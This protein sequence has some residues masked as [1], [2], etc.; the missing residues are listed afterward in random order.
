MAMS[1]D[2]FR[3]KVTSDA[4]FREQLKKDPAGVL[5][6]I[7]WDVPD[8]VDFEVVDM[9]GSKQYLVL[10]PLQSSELKEEELSG[11]QGGCSAAMFQVQG[12]VCTI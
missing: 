4:A 2:E 6:S 8:G 5:K 1:K 11:V 12:P 10:P 7:E 3:A 9:D